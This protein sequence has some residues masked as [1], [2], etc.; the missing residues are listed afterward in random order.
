MSSVCRR[1][2]ACRR[3]GPFAAGT[4]VGPRVFSHAVLI[5]GPDPRHIDVAVSNKLGE[6][7]SQLLGRRRLPFT[8]LLLGLRVPRPDVICLVRVRHAAAPAVDSIADAG[9]L[10]M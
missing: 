6:E 1:S 7:V 5:D 3:C 2:R 10:V 8:R 9:D 4:S